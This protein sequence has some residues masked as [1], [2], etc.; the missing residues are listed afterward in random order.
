M[1]PW[2]GKE[3]SAVMS[4]VYH[5]KTQHL[6]SRVTKIHRKHTFMVPK[7]V[8]MIFLAQDIALVS[9]P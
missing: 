3:E 8:A 9:F 2:Y 7:T 6:V 1:T 5:N 4:Q